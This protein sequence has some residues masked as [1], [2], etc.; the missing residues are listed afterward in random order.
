MH[1]LLSPTGCFIVFG[2]HEHSERLDNTEPHLQTIT[3]LFAWA[4]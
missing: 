4:D 1:L 2:A 3:D